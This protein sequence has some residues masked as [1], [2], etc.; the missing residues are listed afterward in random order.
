MW[1]FIAAFLVLAAVVV[2]FLFRNF[3]A[4]VPLLILGIITV[5]MSATVVDA[6][7]VGIQTSFGRYVDTLDNGLNWTS[8]WSKVEQFST[9]I[10]PLNVTVRV[11][12]EGG[13]SG[14]V[15]TTI[16]WS[17]DKPGAEDLWKAWKTFDR[18]RDNLVKPNSQE[19]VS[20]VVS[21]YQPQDARDGG[22]RAEMQTAVVSGLTQR[23][24]GRGVDI[25]SVSITDIRLD[26]KAQTAVDR[27]VTA[28]ADVQRA[29]SE[30][31]RAK[32]EAE[33]ARIR[34]QSQTPEALQRYC[35]EVVNAW[36]VSKN[37]SLPATFDCDFGGA[38]T[39]VI[40]GAN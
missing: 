35:L 22:N 27:I 3:L 4:L 11:A 39:P 38:G 33:T 12:F 36:D 25:D 1:F 15:D 19:V 10:Q 24:G 5:F 31:D 20:A 6:R 23:L 28:N 32:I 40:V 16:R 21:D 29:Q 13:G 9:Q 18:V 37:G 14:E 2:G 34:Q 8:P 26:S 30:Q 7:A 17:I